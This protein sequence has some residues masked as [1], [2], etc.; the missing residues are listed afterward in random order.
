MGSFAI[1]KFGYSFN[2][3]CSSGSLTKQNHKVT[4][5]TSTFV[6]GVKKSTGLKINEKI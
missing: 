4:D 5:K 3:S 1:E 6:L 2:Q